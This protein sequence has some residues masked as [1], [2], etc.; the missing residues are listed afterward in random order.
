MIAM[1]FEVEPAGASGTARYLQI[2]GKLV[3]HLAQVDGFIGVERFQSLSN[4]DKLLSLSFFRDEAAVEAWRNLPHHRAA[5]A[6]GRSGVF[7]D[8]RLRVAQVIREYGL[9]QRDEAPS[10]S[11]SAHAP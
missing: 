11:R 10:D 6:A 9:T 8:Y 4:P 2:A 1:L 5:Q 7:I 3:Q